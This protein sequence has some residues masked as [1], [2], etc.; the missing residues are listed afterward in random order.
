MDGKFARQDSVVDG[1]Q[2]PRRGRVP[3]ATGFPVTV[4]V[5][6]RGLVASTRR[7]HKVGGGAV[8]ASPN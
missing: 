6:S 7:R 5:R 2:S 8:D 1:G 3:P 4:A